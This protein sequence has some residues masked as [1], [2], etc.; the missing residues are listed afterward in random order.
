MQKSFNIVA[1][2]DITTYLLHIILTDFRAY[3]ST[4]LPIKALRNILS[5][6]ILVIQPTQQKNG[7][8]NPPI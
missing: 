6:A 5:D 1:V 7:N 4:S 3:L 2:A 8:C